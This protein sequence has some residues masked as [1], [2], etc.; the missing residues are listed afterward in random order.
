MPEVVKANIRNLLEQNQ[1][2]I[3]GYIEPLGRKRVDRAETV[4][5]LDYSGYLACWGRLSR[6]RQY[7]GKT[8]PEM[9]MGNIES[10]GLKFLMTLLRRYERPEIETAIKGYEAK[11]IRLKSRQSTEKYLA[12]ITV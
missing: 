5:Y 4:L 12:N 3:E 7:R 11:V 10:F 9:P 1:W 2:I 6:Y 8:R